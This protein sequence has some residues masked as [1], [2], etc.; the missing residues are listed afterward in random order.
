[1]KGWARILAV[2]I[3]R[4]V[5]IAQNYTKS[6]F[7]EIFPKKFRRDSEVFRCFSDIFRNAAQLFSDAWKGGGRPLYT[8]FYY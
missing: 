4:I 6:P 7:C 3:V 2:R 5:R 1:M 8:L